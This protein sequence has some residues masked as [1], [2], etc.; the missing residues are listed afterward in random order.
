[1]IA[2]QDGG[3]LLAANTTEND[4]GDSPW[5][6]SDFRLIKVGPDRQTQ[7]E[8]YLLSSGDDG[9][10]AVVA[11]ADGG[12]LV[13]GV[14]NSP[15]SGDK[16]EDSKELFDFDYWVVKVDRQGAKQWDKTLGGSGQDELMS[17]L[18]T[19]DGGYLLGA[20]QDQ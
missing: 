1:V 16:S 20:L 6:G 2:T 9:L 7:W 10:Q 19:P 11:T 12:Y 15:V 13:G 3:F 5:P 17:I 4:G 18:T 8:K 14:S